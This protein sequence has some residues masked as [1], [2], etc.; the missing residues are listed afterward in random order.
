MFM[1][2]T[3]ETHLGMIYPALLYASMGISVNEICHRS[4]HFIG[5]DTNSAI[6]SESLHRKL[7]NIP[8][9]AKQLTV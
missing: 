2:L 3:Q 4:L 7:T 8:L 5:Q 6:I 1:S 9:V